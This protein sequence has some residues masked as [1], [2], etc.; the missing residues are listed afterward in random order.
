MY[1]VAFTKLYFERGLFIHLFVI[2]VV[3]LINGGLAILIIIMTYYIMVFVSSCANLD[4]MNIL[5]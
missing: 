3:F 5:L 2:V 4:N 1:F